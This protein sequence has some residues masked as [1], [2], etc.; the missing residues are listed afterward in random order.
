MLGFWRRA[1]AFHASYGIRVERVLS[2]NGSAHR[3][4]EFDR[5][6][7][8]EWDVARLYRSEA[9]RTRAFD[10]WLDLY[11]HHR[12]HTDIQGIPVHRV[13]NLSGQNVEVALG[14]A[15]AARSLRSRESHGSAQGWGAELP[16][17]GSVRSTSPLAEGPD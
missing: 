5:E 3:S 2:A 13:N 7:R 1:T 11:I 6:L 8:G 16:G 10:K 9:A 4:R 12:R 15:S 14:R 17:S